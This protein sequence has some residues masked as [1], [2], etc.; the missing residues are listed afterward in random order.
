MARV[1]HPSCSAFRGLAIVMNV[2]VRPLM[3]LS[4]HYR[5]FCRYELQA[6]LIK[7][8]HF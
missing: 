7:T 5:S 8:E 2:T 3:L 4:S 6:E 1:K